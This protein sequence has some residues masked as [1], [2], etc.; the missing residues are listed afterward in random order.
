MVV[1]YQVQTQEGTLKGMETEVC[2]LPS[3]PDVRLRG[4]CGRVAASRGHEALVRFSIKIQN[5]IAEAW[6]AWQ[7]IRPLESDVHV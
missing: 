5:E 2:V 4:Y 1:S 3:C 6:I 7:Y